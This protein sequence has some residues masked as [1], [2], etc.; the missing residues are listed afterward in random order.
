MSDLP[1]E[2]DRRRLLSTYALNLAALPDR[3]HPWRLCEGF[4]RMLGADGG[5]ITV[6]YGEDTRTVLSATDE[7][8][9]GLE[10]FQEIAG[11]GPAHDASS[12]GEAV[13]G[14]FGYGET[15]AWPMLEQTIGE[16]FGRLTL[17]AF[18][19][20]S[21]DD[22]FC[23]VSVYTRDDRSLDEPDAN[24]AF[25]VHAIGAALLAD[26]QKHSESDNGLNGPWTSRVTVH[27][28]TGMIMAQLQV[29]PEDAL[30][31]LRSHAYT[32]DVNVNE[33]ARQVVERKIVFSDTEDEGESS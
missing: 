32:L 22:A 6:E 8:I 17:H 31:L 28:A 11:Q 1:L 5:A 25:L 30:A 10:N 21:D 4:R 33:V 9:A 14:R 2:G 23:V 27:Q 16:Q 26:F 13:V 20:R 15:T 19:T 18:P 7:V 29:P 12:S 3:G 24:I